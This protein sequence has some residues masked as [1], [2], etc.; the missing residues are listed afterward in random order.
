M[1]LTLL[2]LIGALLAAAGAHAAVTAT[3][4]RNKVELNESFLLEVVVDTNIDLEPDI[5]ALQQDFYVG[6]S[7]Q[8]SNTT[9]INGQISRSRT[10]T[11]VLMAK[12]VGQ[13]I[14][15]SL[16]VGTEQSDPLMVIVSETSHAPPGEA[17]VFITSEVDQNEAY[18]QAQVLFRIKIYRAVSTRQPALREPSFGGAEVLVES[19]DDERSYDA[20]L[21]GR[22]YKVVERVFAIF[23]QES[24]EVTISPA[25]FEARVLRDGRITGRKV[26]ESEPQTITVLPIPAPPADYPD[27]A[28]LPARDLELTEHW[29]REPDELLAGEP[30]TRNVTISVLGQLETQIPVTAPP[31]AKGVNIYPDKPELSRR[32]ESGGI[33]GIRTD[34]YA[35]IGVDPGIIRLPAL[36]VPWWD[37]AAGEWRVARLPERTISI[38]PSGEPPEPQQLATMPATTE[39]S[40]LPGIL[41]VHSS[42]WRRVSEGLGVAWLLTLAAWWWSAR[43]RGP[44]RATRGPEPAPI[45]KQQARFLKTARKAAS[46]GDA[47]VLRQALLDWGQLQWPDNAPRSIAVLATRVSSPLADELRRLSRVSYGANAQSWDGAALATALR[48]FALVDNT[49]AARADELLPSLMPPG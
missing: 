39:R 36:E 47:A 35:M 7:S 40:A 10:W 30:I 31:T 17:D 15:P 49:E 45:Y 22:A 28:W 13:L 41:T 1:R 43:A 25:R 46:D 3:V 37:I 32:T 29:S 24:G 42:F 21:N 27:A 34:Q 23:P 5:S 2:L 12:H 16:A 20:I 48:S 18:V 38:L 6:Q 33:R 8:L 4:D 19:A 44:V 26:F 14:I 9:I 11:Y